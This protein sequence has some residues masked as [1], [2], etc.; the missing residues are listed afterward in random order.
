[1]SPED[2]KFGKAGK[3]V[4][5][6]AGGKAV[7]EADASED[8]RPVRPKVKIGYCLDSRKKVMTTQKK[9]D[10]NVQSNDSDEE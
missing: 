4:H 2:G 10:E 9:T 1:M 7:G 5:G 6:L 8:D 3:D